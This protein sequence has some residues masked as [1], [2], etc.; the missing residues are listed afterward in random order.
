MKIGIVLCNLGGPRDLQ[1]VQPFLYRLFTDEEIIPIR[2][3]GI[4]RKAFAYTISYLRAKKTRKKY[5]LIGGKSPINENTEKQRTALQ[6]YLLT[7]FSE[8]TFEVVI[9]MRF[10]FPNAVQAFEA[11]EKFQPEKIIILPLYPHY[12]YNTTQAAI[13]I[14]QR[15]CT[16]KGYKNP[17]H[18]I[19]TYHTHPLYVQAINERIN[20]QLKQVHN[21]ENTILLFSAHGVPVR[22]IAKGDPYQKHIEESVQAIM[23]ARKHD[24]PHLLSY[25]SRVGP[26]EWLKPYTHEVLQ[27]LSQKKVHNVIIIPISFVSDHLETLYEIGVE[28]VQLAKKLNIP[29][30]S[31]TEGLNDHPL[32][33]MAL[34]S[35]IQ[36]TIY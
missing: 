5:A 14:F 3:K 35:L 24:F 21:T 34:A 25:Q 2:L 4:W 30:V 15:I 18:T 9:A 27:E 33:I 28:Y 32:F 20:E 17:V 29:H 1:D 10:G 36:E 11:L 12:S 22:E 8:H 16:E 26:M 23:Q 13:D 7:H 6:K 31:F 19:K